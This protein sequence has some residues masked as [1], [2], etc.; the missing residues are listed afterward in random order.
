MKVCTDLEEVQAH[1]N[2]QEVREKNALSLLLVYDEKDGY[3]P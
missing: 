2:V 3:E 1:G